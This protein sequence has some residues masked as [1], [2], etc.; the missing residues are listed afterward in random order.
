MTLHE[1]E[2]SLKV[3]GRERLRKGEGGF[4][5]E[6]EGARAKLPLRP[7]NPSTPSPARTN[8]SWEGFSGEGW[9]P[10]GWGAKI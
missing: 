8:P 10:K 4:N 3:E 1:G 5:V 7:F 2:A 9:L 6:G